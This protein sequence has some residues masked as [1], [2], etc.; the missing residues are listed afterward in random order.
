MFPEDSAPGAAVKKI[1]GRT[2]LLSGFDGD[3]NAS[4]RTIVVQANYAAS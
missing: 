4:A 1:R 2:I 3:V